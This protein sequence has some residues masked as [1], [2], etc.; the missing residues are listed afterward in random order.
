MS[1]TQA[2]P[3]ESNRRL[4][5][6]ISKFWTKFKQGFKEYWTSLSSDEQ[7][8][9]HLTVC[10]TMKHKFDFE[11]IEFTDVLMRELVLDW[12]TARE[13]KNFLNLFKEVAT[14]DFN[15]L[16]NDQ[17]K[18]LN[19]RYLGQEFSW[20]RIK[21]PYEEHVYHTFGTEGRRTFKFKD[22]SVIS[23]PD[24][25]FHDMLSSGYMRNARVLWMLEIRITYI[26]QHLSL[27]ADEYNGIRKGTDET[28]TTLK[29]LVGCRHC[30]NK[31]K[32]VCSGC[33][34]V[35]YC[36]AEC[37]KKGKFLY[38]STDSVQDWPTHKEKCKEKV[39][40]H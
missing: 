7:N 16:M 28:H 38:H 36:S 6:N 37:Q 22:L 40:D 5:D 27:I 23:D 8:K 33:K 12:L 21:W 31:A 17:F 1:R 11:N 14:K 24:S 29:A 10:P 26:L 15:Q 19:E 25:K 39:L 20:L 18:I 9:V 2:S 13:G 4:H 32:K 35:Y 34:L 3:E 30:G